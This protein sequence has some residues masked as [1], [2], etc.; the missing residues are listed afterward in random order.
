MRNC[1]VTNIIPL[2]N[3]KRQQNRQIK[4]LLQKMI[5]RAKKKT[6]HKAKKASSQKAKKGSQKAK[7]GSQK[8]KKGSFSALLAE[9]RIGSIP[10]SVMGD[11]LAPIGL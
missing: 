11:I 6:S 4:R 10:P 5:L 9:K 2:A 8:A 1:E 3:T 7:K